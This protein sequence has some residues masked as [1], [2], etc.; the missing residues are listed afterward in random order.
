MPT[1]RPQGLRILRGLS[2]GH[3]RDQVVRRA[4]MSAR[5]TPA[6]PAAWEALGDAYLHAGYAAAA[7]DSYRQAVACGADRLSPKAEALR[8]GTGLVWWSDDRDVIAA[9]DQYL[10]MW[11]GA[12]SVYWTEQWM[13]ERFGSGAMIFHESE[14]FVARGQ[15]FPVND[16]VM[17]RTAAIPCVLR[18]EEERVMQLLWRCEGDPQSERHKRALRSAPWRFDEWVA[19]AHTLERQG[20]QHEAELVIGLILRCAPQLGQA[21]I[22]RRQR[23]ELLTASA[24]SDLSVLTA[25]APLMRA[26]LERYFTRLRELSDPPANVHLSSQ[27]DCPTNEGNWLAPLAD[28]PQSIVGRGG[29]YLGTGAG[30]CLTHM[31]Y[32]DATHGYVVDYNPFVTEAVLPAL[33]CLFLAAERAEVWLGACL[34]VPLNERAAAQGNR[35]S[36]AHRVQDVQRCAADKRWHDAVITDLLRLLRPHWPAADRERLG[37][38]LIEFFTA[39]RDPETSTRQAFVAE[40]LRTNAAGRGGFLSSRAAYAAV[41]RLWLEDRVTGVA[42][43]WRGEV[44]ARIGRTLRARGETVQVVYMSNLLEHAIRAPDAPEGIARTL[45]QLRRGLRACPLDPAARTIVTARGTHCLAVV[46]GDAIS[47]LFA[48]GPAEVATAPLIEPL[49]E[50]LAFPRDDLEGLF[51]QL[52]RGSSFSEVFTR[53]PLGQALRALVRRP[54]P[55]L[56]RRDIAHAVQQ[57]ALS[58]RDAWRLQ[59]VI[60]YWQSVL[61]DVT[62]PAGCGSRIG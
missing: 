21:W 44:L 52:A 57:F 36:F 33:A 45:H 16:G 7:R 47:R 48:L 25:A 31:A 61:Q 2:P 5:R 55:G 27:I 28:G 17:R 3:P 50:A 42:A 15:S 32:Q 13:I 8:R 58:A 39:L 62:S 54:L 49:I 35:K 60:R 46:P 14:P 1:L 11:R 19:L 29:V 56:T 53:H 6:A 26:H 43:D 18:A 10:Q 22:L 24:A 4:T 30:L 37:Q 23:E 20:R 34:G 9:A 38:A 12:A 41:R 51:W 59:F 40:M